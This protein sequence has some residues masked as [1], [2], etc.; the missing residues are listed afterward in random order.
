M[1]RPVL[2][3]LGYGPNIGVAV[4]KRFKQEGFSIAVAARNIDKNAVAALGYYG[5]Q[6]DLTDA[7]E[8]ARGFEELENT[9][10]PAS[11]VV[12]NTCEVTPAPG[13]TSDPFSIAFDMFVQSAT[14]TGLNAYQAARLANLGFDKLGPNQSRAFIATGN[15]FPRIDSPQLVGAS[16]GKRILANIVEAAASAYGHAG[17]RFYYAGEVTNDG[18]PQVPP[19]GEAHAHMF[20]DIFQRETQ[21]PWEVPFLRS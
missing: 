7:S 15:L 8:I 1:S 4:A 18:G 19:T 13:G 21:G 5:I 11:V 3:I 9:L 6:L 17:K 12:Y 14:A 2:F 10:G 16:V 20:W